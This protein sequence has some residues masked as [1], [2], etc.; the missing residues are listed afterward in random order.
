[1]SQYVIQIQVEENGAGVGWLAKSFEVTEE[2]PIPSYVAPNR[3][4]IIL[5]NTTSFNEITA[6]YDQYSYP[7]V[8][9]SYNE[10]TGE[11]SCTGDYVHTWP[12]D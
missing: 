11:I 6:T 5:T 4:Q 8:K 10:P 3:I 12:I 9:F 1:M 2:D 7:G